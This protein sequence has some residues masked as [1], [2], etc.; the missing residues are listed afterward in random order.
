M[1]GLL[2]LMIALPLG[3]GFILALTPGK[4]TKAADVFALLVPAGLLVMAASL[5]GFSG[6]YYVG[7][8][9]PPVGI[10]LSIDRF[11][12]ILL[13]GVSLLIFLTALYSARFMTRYTSRI[14]YYVILMMMTAGVNG[15][16][17]AGDI[18]N[19][20]VYVELAAISSYILAG[21]GCSGRELAAALKFAVLGAAASAVTLLGIA[22][23][24]ASYGTVDITSLS[25]AIQ[26]GGG[27]GVFFSPLFLAGVL[28]SAGFALKSALIPFHIWQPDAMEY[29]PA[30]SAALIS[31][32]VVTTTGIYAMV[33]TL[34]S[35][36]GVTPQTGAAVAA[37]GLISAAAGDLAASSAGSYRR[38]AAY[39]SISQTGFIIFGFGIGGRLGAEGNLAAASLVLS[40]GILHLISS[41]FFTPL[42]F[43]KAGS[44]EEL[45]G[46]ESSAAPS[47]GISTIGLF[48]MAGVPPF[49]GF[50]SKAMIIAGC[51]FSGYYL[52][53]AAAGAVSV[54][55]LVSLLRKRAALLRPEGKEP[56]AAIPLLV[57]LPVAL[58]ALVIIGLSLLAAP[59]LRG[60]VLDPAGEGVIEA[61]LPE[62][63]EGAAQ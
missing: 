18:F 3:A 8:W 26:A 30:P 7:G 20:F 15:T 23:L 27:S 1:S 35:V 55:T 56:A 19:R 11:S 43:L 42:I 41:I 37:L 53:A 49:P 44:A 36:F 22:V 4:L 31:G 58:M 45:R 9:A 6:S 25:A 51:Y 52:A 16:L 60:R 39:Y 12:G 24:Y 61:F 59:R 47:K 13:T 10:T 63:G 21:F 32:A 40:G 48:S 34:F 2:P 62:T 50:F 5:Y 33:R 14:K 57:K 38:T 29:S 54:R 28:M 46:T 17:L